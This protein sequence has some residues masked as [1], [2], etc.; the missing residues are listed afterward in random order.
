VCQ[1]LE[2]SGNKDLILASSE[3]APANIMRP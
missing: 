1:S 3:S 2:L